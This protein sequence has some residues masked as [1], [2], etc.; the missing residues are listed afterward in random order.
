[1][2]KIKARQFMGTMLGI[3]NGGSLALMLSIGHRT[4]LLDVMA[5]MGSVSSNQLAEAA[6]LDERYVREWLAAMTAGGIIEYSS[7]DQTYVLPE[8]HATLVTRAGGPLNIASVTQYIALLGQ[9]EDDVVDAFTTGAGVGYDRYPAFQALM[10]EQSSARFNAG[11]LNETLPAIQGLTDRLASGIDVAD[12]GCGSGYALVLMAKAYP[13]SSF[14]G[15]DFSDEALT[16]ARAAARDAE[17]SNL[18]FVAEDAAKIDASND[19]DF[20]TTFDAIHDQAQPATVLANIAKAL[21][22]D[23]TYLCVE[24]KA[25]S[26]L[27]DNLDDPMAPYLYTVSTMHCMSVSIAGGG[28]GLGTAWGTERTLEY[29]ANA[30]FSDVEHHVR[31][32]D[33]T[34]THFVCRKS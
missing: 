20:I 26:A 1:M 2:D 19:Y 33:R 30:G 9:V 22:D 24:P 31:K 14:T 27:E 4:G 34:N 8:E 23:G 18:H 10:A 32:T 3:L 12:I 16:T 29:L 11:L 21:R 15:F 25:A 7:V 17:L 13:N 28:E 5:P 6:G